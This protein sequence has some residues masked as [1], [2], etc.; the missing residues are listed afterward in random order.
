MS[1][2][3]HHDHHTIL[4]FDTVNNSVLDIETYRIIAFQLTCE[5]FPS[6]WCD[7]DFIP[8]NVFEFILEF[9][10]ELLDVFT[11]LSGELNPVVSASH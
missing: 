6:F 8:K 11:C 2:S 1:L 9:R 5:R 3:A 4:F 7:S 10:C